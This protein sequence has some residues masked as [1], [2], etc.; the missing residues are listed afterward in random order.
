MK[1]KFE[2]TEIWK[3]TLC[4]RDDYD[5]YEKHRELLRSEFLNFREKAKVLAGEISRV[6]PE[7]TVHDIKHI[8]ALW[9]SASLMV[10]EDFDINPAEAFVLGGAFLIHDLGMGLTSFPNGI[11]ELKKE[12]I[13]KD[14]V[15]SLTKRNK[16]NYNIDKAKKADSIDKDI[17]TIATETVLRLLH[18][19]HSENL[20]KI[21][22]KDD[23]GNNIFLI[24]NIEL[25]EA[26]GSIIGL[27]AYSHCWKVSQLEEK[28]P[29]IK[30]A[31]GDFPS[32]WTIDPIKIASILRIAD[33]IQIDDRR[34][35]IF[36][37]ALRKPKDYSKTHWD[38]Q[39]KLYKPILKNNRLLYTSK[40][41]FSINEVDSWWIC[42]DTLKMI[43]SELKEVDS[44]LVDTN[45]QQLNALGV[46]GV[47]DTYR[48]SKLIST[49]GWEPVDTNI[50]VSNVAELVNKLGGSQLYGDNLLVPLR[51][52]IQ[53]AADA[54]RARR[55]YEEEDE[56]F[57][58]IKIKIGN[59]EYGEYIEVEDNGIGMSSR[60][61]TGPFLDFGQSFWGSSLMYEEL[62]G[63][64]SKGF[65]STGKYGIGFFSVFIW[66][67]KVSIYTKRFEDGRDST[68]V[69]E[70]N[71]GASSRPLLRKAK[72]EEYIKDG[73]TRIRIRLDK[74]ITTYDILNKKSYVKNSNTFEE[75]IKELCLS[76]DCNIILETEGIKK[77]IIHANE[78]KIIDNIEFM[79]RIIGFSKYNKLNNI[80]KELIE[81]LSK[82]LA[83]IVEDDGRIVGRACIFKDIIDEKLLRDICGVV[84]VGGVRT[85]ELSGI[86]GVLEGISNRASR[87]IG[88]PIVSDTKLSEW[89][90]NQAEVLMNLNLTDEQQI[91]SA[92][93]IRA[94]SGKTLGLKIA[95]NK[96]GAVNYEMIKTLIKEENY[97]QC[98]I[99]Q[100]A[101]V[102]NYERVNSVKIDFEK[103]IFWVDC[104]IPGILQTR[105]SDIYISWPKFEN[106]CWFYSLSLK[107]LIYEAFSE[108]HKKDLNQIIEDSNI[109]SD[110]MV[111]D[112]IV[113]NVEGEIIRFEYVDIIINNME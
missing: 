90:T 57:G 36:L 45:R 109:S 62:P 78:W 106:K 40:S 107:G 102:S 55:I 87:D 54:I 46:I 75:V 24:E 29:D 15:A 104:S 76:I 38:F 98:I 61:L 69:L 20:A 65:N 71:E 84:T 68:Q 105:R 32:E 30:G 81:K 42:Y 86:L 77:K 100:D 99:A 9:E 1:N 26:Y 17:E 101:A 73:G 85:S 4:K 58:D 12:T 112:A 79:K 72:K 31:L 47:D 59:D 44:L 8:D 49:D 6:L 70:F 50:K 35:P 67:K 27:I 51:E 7:F 93:I 96:S 110:E 19:K 39:Q 13:W 60:V 92:S 21:S 111:Y 94:C 41:S 11:D 18:A 14:T 88:I 97:S 2:N 108:V 91:E 80:E 33:A 95:Y 83:L 34:A 63:L 74:G 43:D 10:G 66:G 89:A 3:K 28:L 103:N 25:R 52:L 48:I 16:L 5:I 23:K 56:S 64:E 113:G 82:N 37:R 22:W 53:N